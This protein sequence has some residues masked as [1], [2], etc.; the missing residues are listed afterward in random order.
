MSYSDSDENRSDRR[1]YLG[2]AKTI[3]TTLFPDA[4]W[5]NLAGKLPSTIN[6][7]GAL[8]R[9]GGGGGEG[10]DI[11]I[12]TTGS[13]E[14]RTIGAFSSGINA[15]SIGGGGGSG[16]SSQTGTLNVADDGQIAGGASIGGKGGSGGD[17]GTVPY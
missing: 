12:T 5:A 6:L 10:G 1:D 13:G 14:I 2:Y 4:D 16:G 3:L 11:T 7:S 9:A 8:G 15:H 17:G